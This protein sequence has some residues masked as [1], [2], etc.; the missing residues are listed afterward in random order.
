MIRE[1]KRL[2]CEDSVRELGLFTLERRTLQGVL[3]AVFQYL[4]GAYKN[5]GEGLFTRVCSDRTRGK[6]FKLK[7]GEFILDLRKKFFARRVVRHWHRF[8]RAV[9]HAPSVNVFKAKLDGALSNL[10]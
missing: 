7:E 3:L 8:P 4:K 1:L 2:F 9:V 10:V 5:T 6:G